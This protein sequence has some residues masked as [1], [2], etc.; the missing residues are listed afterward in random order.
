[1][2]GKTFGRLTVVREVCDVEKKAWQLRYRVYD[3]VCACGN[4]TLATGTELR[5]GNKRSCGCLRKK[6]HQRVTSRQ[7]DL[8]DFLALFIHDYP[9]Y[10][11]EREWAK[12][13]LFT[14][15]FG[16]LED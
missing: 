6:A 1:M 13:K 9:L 5:A 10:Y 7:S 2:I 3:C 4:H 12:Y 11:V 14:T 16:H 15:A 8:H